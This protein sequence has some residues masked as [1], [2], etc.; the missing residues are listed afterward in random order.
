MCGPYDAQAM[1]SKHPDLSRETLVLGDDTVQTVVRAEQCDALAARHIAHV[2]VLDAAAPYTVVRTNLSGAFMQVC[3]GG[4]GQTLLDGRWYTHKPGSVTFAPAHVLHAFHCV[5]GKRWQLAWVRFKPDSVRSVD[6]AM[7]PTM[8]AFD[9]R[10]LQNA[11][12]GLA[13]EMEGA[14]DPG[15]CVVWVDVIERYVARILEPLQREPRLVP[16]WNAVKHDLARDWTLADLAALANTSEEHLRRLCQKN[17][18]RSP[19][20]QLTTL[21]I[22]HAAHLLATT[23]EKIEAIA[24]AVGYVNPFAFSNTFKRLTGFRPSD[25]RLRHL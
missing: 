10:V 5:P 21:R 15:T 25:Y 12:L 11:I 8:T 1:P 18:G 6:G 2:S 7:A 17:L 14:A 13:A 19:G 24:H 20:K 16:V 23:T 22:A 9:G 3:L 4:E